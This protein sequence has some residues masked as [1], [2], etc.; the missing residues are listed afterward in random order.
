MSH[1]EQPH[2]YLAKLLATGEEVLRIDHQHGFVAFGL[3]SGALV[4]MIAVGVITSL[5]WAKYGEGRNWIIY[6]Y[7]LA[8]LGLPHLV[9]QL[10]VWRAHQYIVTNR[11]VLQISGVFTKEVIEAFRAGGAGWQSRINDALRNVARKP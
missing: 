8:V 10:T 2:G 6:G 7:V 9:W 11:R 3:I 5:L 1:T 4:Y